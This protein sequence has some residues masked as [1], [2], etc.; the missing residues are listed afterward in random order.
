MNNNIIMNNRIFCNNCGNYGHNYR[1]CVEPITSIGIIGYTKI[2]NITK[3]LMIRRKDTLGFVD[4]IRGKYNIN[5][6]NYLLN[7]IN[8]MTINEKKNILELTF[9]E[10]W[11]QLWD[12]NITIKYMNEKTSSKNK[13]NIL[14]KGIVNNEEFYNLEQLINESNTNW[15][16]QEWGFPK[17]RRNYK[18]ND[19]VA[20]L[21]EFKEE[22]G[23]NE[24]YI[25]IIKNIEP[26]EEIFIGSNFKSYKHKYYLAEI[27]GCNEFNDFEKSEVSKVKLFT[28]DE[29]LAFIRN[30]NLEKKK[31]IKQ[32]D[33]IIN[34]YKI[35][36]IN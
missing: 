12:E 11:N 15:K 19:I 14:K 33:E 21:R 7:I 23:I 22:T 13:F 36:N 3:Y 6:K 31:I 34:N 4:F 10:L 32:V 1:D 35:I 5:N 27:I 24:K 28:L 20:G 18:E 17:G 9:D 25:K 2:N 30:Y 29:C 8:E 16:E 26:F